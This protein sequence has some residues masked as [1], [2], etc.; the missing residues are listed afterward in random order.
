[1]LILAAPTDELADTVAPL[2]NMLRFCD[3]LLDNALDRFAMGG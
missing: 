3:V 2:E 1:M